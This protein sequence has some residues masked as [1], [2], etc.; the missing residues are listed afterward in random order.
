M[1]TNQKTLYLEQVLE[2]IMAGTGTV[3]ILQVV[4]MTLCGVQSQ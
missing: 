1:Y 2:A 3:P 4:D